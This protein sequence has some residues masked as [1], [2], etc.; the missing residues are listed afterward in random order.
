MN[1]A[2]KKALGIG[3]LAAG[4]YVGVRAIQRKLRHFD[5]EGK[6]VLITG[7]SRGLGLVLARQFAQEGCR[8]AICARNDAELERAYE[9]LHRRTSEV[10]SVA[11][12]ISDRD[13]VEDMVRKVRDR[14]SEIHVLVNNAGVIEVGPM[15]VQTLEDYEEA[16]NAHFWGP[17]SQHL[18]HR[19]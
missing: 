15:E 7:G 12:D 17:H 9:D 16:M 2:A 3:A 19:R 13:Q 6:T 11:C 5:L 8:V 10:M 4:A 18:F 1:D 14:F